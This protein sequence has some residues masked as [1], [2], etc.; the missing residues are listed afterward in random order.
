MSVDNK[1]IDEHS[2][3][4]RLCTTKQK[5]ATHRTPVRHATRPTLIQLK[6]IKYRPTRRRKYFVIQPGSVIIGRTRKIVTN[7]P[8]FRVL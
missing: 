7:D 8:L 4:N 1:S 5:C 6:L 2:K 3:V